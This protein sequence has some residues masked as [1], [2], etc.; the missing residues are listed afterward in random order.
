MVLNLLDCSLEEY[1]DIRL[2]EYLVKQVNEEVA[3]CSSLRLCGEVKELAVNRPTI[4]RPDGLS[5]F[6]LKV[7][8]QLLTFNFGLGNRASL[9]GYDRTEVCTVCAE[10]GINVKLDE[11]HFTIR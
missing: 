3:G 5:R 1:S 2:E 8:F 9:L 4:S 11:V 10:Y 7:Y 6:Q